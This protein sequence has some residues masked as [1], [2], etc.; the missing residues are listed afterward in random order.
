MESTR[1]PA[2]QNVKNSGETSNSSTTTYNIIL[3]TTFTA[4][5]T[6]STFTVTV[7]IEPTSNVSTSDAAA[8]DPV[9]CSSTTYA[10]AALA[11]LSANNTASSHTADADNTTFVSTTKPT[12][13]AK[14]TC[15][16]AVL[17]VVALA[18]LI[19]SLLSY[20]VAVVSLPATFLT[21]TITTNSSTQ[22][23]TARSI[24]F[25]VQ[26]TSVNVNAAEP[27][28]V[29][30]IFDR[31]NGFV[32]T[33]SSNKTIMDLISTFRDHL[34]V[35]AITIFLILCTFLLYK[36]FRLIYRQ[37]TSRKG[38][39]VVNARHKVNPKSGKK[40]FLSPH[41]STPEQYQP[42]DEVTKHPGNPV[43]AASYELQEVS[44]SW[45]QLDL[46]SMYSSADSCTS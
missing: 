4:T 30:R 7:C 2:L 32:D 34:V 43:G 18:L 40:A 12:T 37:L 22:E 35:W 38:K 27:S 39:Y 42:A 26:P 46:T 20:Q 21:Q 13:I 5:S 19:I 41:E 14:S 11:L 28:A 15:I 45:S 16:A 29:T 24:T 10:D 17:S 9:T 8:T 44:P 1:L 23:E 25:P 33:S 6:K 36:L 31:E 3:P